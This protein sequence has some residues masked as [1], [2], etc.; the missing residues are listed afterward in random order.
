MS[1]L[2]LPNELLLLIASS[3]ENAV[4]I[5]SFLL[6]N[7][8][9]S[10]LLHPLFLNISCTRPHAVTALFWA[11]VTGNEYTTRH[12]L[13]HADNVLIARLLP[14]N[15]TKMILH[16]TPGKYRDTLL[17]AIFTEAA[18]GGV[19]IMDR[20]TQ[21][22]ALHRA[23]KGQNN[24]LVQRLLEKGADTTAQ[25][26][27]GWTALHM[28]ARQGNETVV[29]MLLDQ[30][31][32]PNTEGVYG[33]SPL[34]LAGGYEG[35]ARLL[36]EHGADVTVKDSYG[37]TPLHLS[38]RYWGESL[39]RSILD[40]GA[41]I[42]IR[43]NDDR[44]ALHLAAIYGYGPL[45]VLL[46]KGADITVQDIFGRT[47]LHMASKQGREDSLRVLLEAGADVAAQDH[48]GR[49]P[50]HLAASKGNEKAVRLLLDQ[51]ANL[52]TRDHVGR[53]A[54]QLAVGN[55]RGTGKWMWGMLGGGVVGGNFLAL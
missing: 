47:P 12:I 36:I 42:T 26:M 10:N 34:C 11:A 45:R 15:S 1:L 52:S 31:A 53:T 25:D 29:R 41:M 37:R 9:L 20:Y 40:K 8:R 23:V 43:D 4:D 54:F 5:S 27:G 2:E 32:D 51:G 19:K 17:K 30:H 24:R 49:T 13:S 48:Y 21:E 39:T 6:T 22:T 55:E 44:T 14:E 28:A 33:E 3:L 18:S 7:R 50:L 46:E 35:V 38:V 16:A